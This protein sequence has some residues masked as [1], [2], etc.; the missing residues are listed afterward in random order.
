MKA[1][2][3]GN[4]GTGQGWQGTNQ[5]FWCCTASKFSLQSPWVTGKNYAI[6][7]MLTGGAPLTEFSKARNYPEP[8]YS[9]TGATVYDSAVN[10]TRILGELRALGP[11]EEQSLYEAQLS[12]RLASG[13]RISNIVLL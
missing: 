7:C 5:V 8:G 12:E 4:S 9:P 3:A 2:D 6:G 1:I 13:N 11:G 10:G